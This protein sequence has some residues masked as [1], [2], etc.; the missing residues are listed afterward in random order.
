M[1]ACTCLSRFHPYLAFVSFASVVSDILSFSDMHSGSNDTRIQM[2][3]IRIAGVTQQ[4]PNPNR[5]LSD[6]DMTN[7]PTDYNNVA[8][9]LPPP[10]YKDL[11]LRLGWDFA[12][13]RVS[14]KVY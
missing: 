3:S 4:A 14:R 8:L 9:R 7:S 10:N 5:K 11:R 6:L 2:N 13:D 12:W 1:C